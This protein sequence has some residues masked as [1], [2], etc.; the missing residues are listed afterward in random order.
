MLQI[1]DLSRDLPCFQAGLTK[2]A[3][4][5]QPFDLRVENPNLVTF[6]AE[7]VTEGAV[8]DDF[9]QGAPIIESGNLFSKDV[10][11]GGRPHKES[12][13]PARE[14]F[15]WVLDVVWGGEEKFDNVRGLALCLVLAKPSHTSVVE[16]LDPFG[17]D[18]GPIGARDVKREGPP[19][20][21]LVPLW[22][23]GVLD[24][25]VLDASLE[26][27]DLNA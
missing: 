6:F 1:L 5:H 18:S 12:P 8:A 24:F 9:G 22:T 13:E 2:S 3:A 25:V 4:L 15:W 7:L 20:I 16:L 23:F 19:H 27:L 21:G 10:K 26:C 11:G 17:E 14:G